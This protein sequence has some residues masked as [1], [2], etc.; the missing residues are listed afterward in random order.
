MEEKFATRES[1]QSRQ[2]A[3]VTAPRRNS[4]DALLIRLRRLRRDGRAA[5]QKKAQL[6][7]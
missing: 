6:F 5:V 3:A 2:V 4:A 1:F 7:D